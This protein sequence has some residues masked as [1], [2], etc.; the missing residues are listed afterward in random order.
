MELVKEVEQTSG[1]RR[2]TSV[3]RNG[4]MGGTTVDEERS[5]EIERWQTSRQKEEKEI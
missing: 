1:A 3:R 2:T 5:V 4:K